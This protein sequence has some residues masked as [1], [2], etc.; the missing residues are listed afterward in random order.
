MGSIS[1]EYYLELRRQFLLSQTE[2][3]T[4]GF[5]RYIPRRHFDV[6]TGCSK[7]GSYGEDFR[8]SSQVH[9]PGDREDFSGF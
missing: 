9:V 1:V 5:C 6:L 8:S 4:A 2:G 7:K 3:K